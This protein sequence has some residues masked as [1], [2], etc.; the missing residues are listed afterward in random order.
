MKKKPNPK[1]TID[2]ISS[3]CET[4]Y[5]A[6]HEV[7]FGNPNARLSQDYGMTIKLCYKHHQGD[8]GVH[9][10]DELNRKLKREYQLKFIEMYP[11]KDFY[12]IFK[13]NYL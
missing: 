12:S 4:P 5:A 11:D 13:K 10:N 9:F 1:P 8:N 7:F 2:D 3:I 6:T